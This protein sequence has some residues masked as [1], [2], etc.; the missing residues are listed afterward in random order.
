MPR[1][2]GWSEAELTSAVAESRSLAEVCR[3]LGLRLGGGTYATL[4]RHIA[5]LGL[6]AGHLPAVVEGRVRVRRSWSDDDLRAAVLASTSVAEVQRR[7][8][9][10]PSG[11]MHR[12]IRSHI[13]R[14]GLSTEHFR[15]QS[16]AR[17]RPPT[18]GFVPRPLSE[19]LVRDSTYVNSARLRRRLIRA[20]LKI[21]E[22]ERCGLDAWQ[23]EPLPLAL[24]HI[25]GEST[26]NRLENLR[27]LCPNCHALTETWCGRNKGRRTPTVERP[28]L[29]SGQC[30]FES[31]RRYRVDQCHFLARN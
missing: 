9:F 22:C 14:L 19:V 30:G 6:D 21:A 4:H 2:P 24:D 31:R 23:G 27:I 25:N 29:G 3:R 15:G 28:D 16:W 10:T 20:G 12:S 11:G 17:G 7:L 1:S 5:R 26:D 13:L 18:Q 8:G